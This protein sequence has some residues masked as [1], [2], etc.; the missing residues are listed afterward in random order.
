[1]MGKAFHTRRSESQE[2]YLQMFGRACGRS[3]HAFFRVPAPGIGYTGRNAHVWIRLGCPDADP[4]GVSWPL[5][6][7]R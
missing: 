3:G 2:T 7:A 6:D 4:A 5:A 1:M